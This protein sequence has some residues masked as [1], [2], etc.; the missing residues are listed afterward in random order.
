MITSMDTFT[1]Q[2]RKS[3]M[4]RIRSKNTTPEII[5]RKILT[6]LHYRYRL[7]VTNLP[8]KPDIVIRKSKLAIFINGCFWHQHQGCKRQTLPKTNT[9]YWYKKLQ[10]NVERQ[11]KN[12]DI[13]NKSGWNTVI[14]WEC[15]TKN[16][17]SLFSRLQGVLSE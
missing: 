11:N 3:C 1:K 15:E 8:G 13:L 2:Q 7:Q 4:S 17:T 16:E 12:I 5:V 6:R 14:V 10:G 9:E